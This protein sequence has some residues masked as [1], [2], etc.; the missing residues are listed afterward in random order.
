MTV[1]VNN[2][3][4]FHKIITHQTLYNS[5]LIYQFKQT[6]YN[7]EVILTGGRPGF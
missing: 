3:I 2:T 4:I 5:S 7:V 6:S 1:A